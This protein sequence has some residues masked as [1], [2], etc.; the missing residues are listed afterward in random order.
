MMKTEL[1]PFTDEMVP[2]AGKLLAG[3]HARNRESLALLPARFEDPQV[4]AKAVKALWEKKQRNGYGAFRDG[5]MSAYLLGEHVTQPWGRCG[6]VYLPGYALDEG[7]STKTLQNLYARLGDDWVRKGVFS[8]GLYISAADQEVIAALFDLGFGKER[9][10]AL[11]DLRG[12][13]IP[14]HKEPEGITVRRAGKGD[15]PLLGGISDVISR[16]LAQPPYWHPTIPE[17]WEGLREG[18]S[19]LA[20]EKDWTIWMALDQDEL[21][22]MVLGSPRRRPPIPTC[23]PPHGPPI[24]ASQ[25]R[26]RRHADAGSAPI[27]PGG[28]SSRRARMDSKSAIPTGSAPTSWQPVTGRAS[29]SRKSP[30]GW[31]SG[32][33]R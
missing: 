8:H 17:D 10:D 28:D 5:R 21:L 32:S 29:G 1:V 14:E 27:S 11:L 3:R 6:Y 33:I 31:R 19:E 15:N 22:G 13:E 23:S 25:R 16:A 12:L 24:S 18:W 2:A 20:D 9:V 26:S 4:A 7:E 30:T